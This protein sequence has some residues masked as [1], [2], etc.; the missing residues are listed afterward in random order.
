[1]KS[2]KSAFGITGSRLRVLGAGNENMALCSL[3][4]LFIE[5]D[6]VFIDAGLAAEGLEII[7]LGVRFDVIISDYLMPDMN[8]I[9]FLSAVRT[10]QPEALRI[11]LT[12]QMP[13]QEITAAFDAGIVHFQVLK[14]WDDSELLALIEAGITL[15]R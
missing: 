15:N 12:G 13:R 4:R 7:Q 10:L 1:M 3:R 11:L 14:P 6:F 2:E 9:E 8:G 5:H